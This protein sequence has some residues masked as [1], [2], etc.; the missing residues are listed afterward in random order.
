M[1]KLRAICS[2]SSSHI[3]FR[4]PLQGAA[5]AVRSIKFL[6]IIF[7]LNSILEQKRTF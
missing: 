7:C 3:F 2:R 1:L 5:A 4:A 6:Y